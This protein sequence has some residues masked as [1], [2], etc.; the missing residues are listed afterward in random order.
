MAS[1]PKVYLAGPDVFLANAGQV[2][3][4]KKDICEQHGMIGV[5][6]LDNDIED[7]EGLNGAMTI[8]AGNEAAMDACDT[9]VANMTPFRGPSMDVGTAYEMGYMRAAGKPVFGYTNDARTFEDRIEAHF[10][11][12][13]EVATLTQREGQSVKEDPDGM[14]V[15]PFGLSENLMMVAAVNASGGEVHQETTEADQ[16]FSDLTAFE[17]AVAQAKAH[18]D[19]RPEQEESRQE[20]LKELAECRDALAGFDK[21]L[22]D[23]R[24]YGFSLVTVLLGSSGFLYAT[25]EKVTV[26]PIIVLGVQIAL[27]LLI[28]NLFLQDRVQQ[29]FIRSTVLRALELERRLG[30]KLTFQIAYWSEKTETATW[31]IT[32]YFGFCIANSALAIV[33][34]I[35]REPAVSWLW[36]VLSGT[37]GAFTLLGIWFAHIEA[38]DL[39]I[40]FNSSVDLMASAEGL[41]KI[42]RSWLARLL[43]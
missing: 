18:M 13:A 15:E 26:A 4:Q 32:L 3:Q 28:Y 33:G 42:T 11:D 1:A 40:K 27:L 38:R 31:G 8:S 10:S 43:R 21:S 5:S 41:P 23:L 17:A 25:T 9:V 30:L 12:D 35:D 22:Q 6:P 24:K 7:A 14:A 16:L 19:A 37:L 39:R 20:Q 2:L 29:V 36:F 34:F